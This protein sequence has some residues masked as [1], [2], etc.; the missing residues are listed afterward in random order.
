MNSNSNWI[1]IASLFITF[2]VGMSAIAGLAYYLQKKTKSHKPFSR[3]AV[4]IFSF[5]AVTSVLSIA[6]INHNTFFDLGASIVGLFGVVSTI[7]MFVM[8]FKFW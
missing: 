6:W 8:K 4:F 2:L 5:F 7:F 3:W 1:E